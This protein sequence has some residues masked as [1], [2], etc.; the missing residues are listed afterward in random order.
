[1]SAVSDDKVRTLVRQIAMG[2]ANSAMAGWRLMPGELDLDKISREDPDLLPALGSRAKELRITHPWVPTLIGVWRHTWV[3]NQVALDHLL[4]AQQPRF[5]RGRPA[6]LV[7]Y[8]ATTGDLSFHTPLS[9]RLWVDQPKRT[10]AVEFHGF[11]LRVPLPAQHALQSL[12]YG[13]EID[14][15]WAMQHTEMDWSSFQAEATRLGLRS[16]ISRRL[17]RLHDLLGSSVVPPSAVRELTIS[18]ASR[19]TDL[20][21]R[22]AVMLRTPVKR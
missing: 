19:G 15:A 1:M 22:G 10:M 17:A 14:A 9:S 2:P 20:A 11:P 13:A 4:R 18:R 12:W 7:A 5:V 16:G 3:T 8:A 21:K 6:T